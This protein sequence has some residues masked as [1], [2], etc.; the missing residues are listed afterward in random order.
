MR[1]GLP[2]GH[3]DVAVS[4]VPID[5]IRADFV[6]GTVRCHISDNLVS[7][8]FRNDGVA[9]GIDVG[10]GGVSDLECEL[11]HEKPVS[12]DVRGGT[13]SN[14]VRLESA[15]HCIAGRTTVADDET[16]LDRDQVIALIA[17]HAKELAQLAEAQGCKTLVY[18]LESAAQQAEKQLAEPPGDRKSGLD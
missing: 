17:K 2:R 13:Q 12:G 6:A 18:L 3:G 4:N 11:G 1:C 8:Q 15:A 14:S 10:I 16:P 7:G 5:A 9:L